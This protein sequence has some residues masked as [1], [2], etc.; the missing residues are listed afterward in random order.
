[1]SEKRTITLHEMNARQNFPLGIPDW[2]D[3]DTRLYIGFR[4]IV[5]AREWTCIIT[6]FDGKKTTAYVTC[7]GFYIEHHGPAI[8]SYYSDR[9][10]HRK[11]VREWFRDFCG[12]E[13]RFE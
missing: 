6:H 11:V 13:V 3:E 2:V 5:A 12:L 8:N 9:A 4:G 1:M 7:N 10:C